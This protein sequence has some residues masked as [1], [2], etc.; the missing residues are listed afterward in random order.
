MISEYD[1]DAEPDADA[2]QKTPEDVRLDLVITYHCRHR[3]SL[4]RSPLHAAIHVVVENQLALG[5]LD[6]VNAIKRLQNEGLDRHEAIHA[7]GTVLIEHLSDVLHAAGEPGPDVHKEYFKR[8]GDLTA[9]DWRQSG[10]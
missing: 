2:W 4:P 9:D 3:V 7:V 5:E 1:P 8:L 6:V 10:K